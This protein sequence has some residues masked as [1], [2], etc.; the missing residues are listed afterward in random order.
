MPYKSFAGWPIGKY[1]DLFVPAFNYFKATDSWDAN[2]KKIKGAPGTGFES[3]AL[4]L[5]E[6]YGISRRLDFIAS[7]PVV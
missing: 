4:N 3:Y 7:L 6:G 2:G 1:H 5:F